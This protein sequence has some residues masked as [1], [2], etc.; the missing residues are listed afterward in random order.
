MD[1]TAPAKA[2]A[3]ALAIIATMPVSMPVAIASTWTVMSDGAT[4]AVEAIAKA[5]AGGDDAATVPT[6]GAGGAAASDG[7]RYDGC[8]EPST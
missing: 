1:N 6:T 3:G 5:V 2:D 7:E 8:R 4:L